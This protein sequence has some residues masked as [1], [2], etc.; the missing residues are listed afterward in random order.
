MVEQRYKAV[1]AVIADG[2][3]VNRAGKSGGSIS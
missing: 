1:L 3:D 2:L